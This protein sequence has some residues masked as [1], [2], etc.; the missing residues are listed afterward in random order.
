MKKTVG[1]KQK[2]SEKAMEL[3]EGTERVEEAR[4]LWRETQKAEA[5]AEERAAEKSKAAAEEQTVEKSKA[6][7][8]EQ[9]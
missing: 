2:K 1:K 3:L 7:E 6:A 8:K 9:E 5:A 4:K